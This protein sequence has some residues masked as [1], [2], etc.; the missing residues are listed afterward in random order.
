MIM[1]TTLTDLQRSILKARLDCDI[2]FAKDICEIAGINRASTLNAIAGERSM[3]VEALVRLLAVL[4]IDRNFEPLI[5]VPHYLKVGADLSSIYLL[6]QHVFKVTMYWWI[7]DE[8]LTKHTLDKPAVG[9]FVCEFF[10]KNE[11]S[12]LLI[13]R[14]PFRTGRGVHL[15]VKPDEAEAF[16]PGMQLGRQ[17]LLENA[18]IEMSLEFRQELEDIFYKGGKPIGMSKL[19]HMLFGRSS[20]ISWN[21]VIRYSEQRGMKAEDVMELVSRAERIKLVKVETK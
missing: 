4:D 19:Q 17:E 5:T 1:N 15:N 6:L 2:R 21:Q 14:D 18:C 10:H 13:Q 7:K 16:Q 9:M 8:N 11:G 12:L 20:E 3:P